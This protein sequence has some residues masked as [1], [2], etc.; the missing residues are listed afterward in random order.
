MIKHKRIKNLI[1]IVSDPNMN[2]S[3]KQK[4]RRRWNCSDLDQSWSEIQKNQERYL[5]EG[6][7][8]RSCSQLEQEEEEERSEGEE[9]NEK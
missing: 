8:S 2:K 3:S 6:E 9:S 7:K 5:K 4:R 1:K